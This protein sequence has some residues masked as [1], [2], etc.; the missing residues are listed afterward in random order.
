[1]KKR[2]IS[3]KD[4]VITFQIIIIAFGIMIGNQP[5]LSQETY[6]LLFKEDFNDGQAQDWELE[7]GWFVAENMLIGQY[8]SWARPM[9]GPWQ[10]FRL[11]FRLKLQQGVIHLVY[12]LNDTG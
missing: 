2:T 12:R 6:T 5:V 11:K 10:D 9:I 4:I 1:L 7:P 3:L 8:H